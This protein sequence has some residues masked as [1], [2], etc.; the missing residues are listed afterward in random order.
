MEVYPLIITIVF[1]IFG[2][3]IGSFINVCIYRIPKEE[4]LFSPGSHCTSCGRFISW[5]DNI[6]LLSFIFLKGK[7]RYCKSKISFQYPLVEFLTGICFLFVA[8]KFFGENIFPFYL[9]LTFA[10]IAVFFIDLYEQIIP[11]FFSFSLILIGLVSSVMNPHLGHSFLLRAA[12]SLGGVVAGGGILL[13]AGYAGKILFKKEAMGLGDIKFLAG[14]GAFSGAPKVVLV[15]VIA[16]VLGSIWGI[17]LIT[18]K[19]INK[20]DYIPF[21]PFISASAFF[22]LFIKI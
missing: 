5:H 11:D 14:I 13:L 20:R 22:C 12:N 7:C 19:K 3:V 10:L 6:P 16:S 8:A 18:L 17:V 9:Y 2:L 1:F 4:S 15:L 21:G